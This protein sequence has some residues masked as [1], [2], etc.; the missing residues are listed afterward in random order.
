LAK[1]PE[2]AVAAKD[3][4]E[5]NW[6]ERLFVPHRDGDKV[7]VPVPK[8]INDFSENYLVISILKIIQ[9]RGWEACKSS[10]EV[11]TTV[12]K[13]E[14]NMFFAGYVAGCMHDTCGKRIKASNAYE[15]GVLSAQTDAVIASV[16]NRNAHIRK[17]EHTCGKIL[18]EMGGFVREHWATRSA[19]AMLF[20]DLP[21]P[22][23][24]P[25]DLPSYML[26][27]GELIGKIVR[28]SLPHSNG[29][30]FRKEELAYLNGKYAATQQMLDDI[31]RHCKAPGSDFANHFWEYID[32]LSS[33]A[34]QIEKDLGV[35]YAHRA[36]VL[37]RQGSKKKADIKWIRLSLEE[38]IDQLSLSE[39]GKLFDP[40]GL[41]GFTPVTGQ[42]R[43]EDEFEEWLTK[44]YRLNTSD[45]LYNLK[46]AVVSS[47]T[48]LRE[49]VLASD[50]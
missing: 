27:G 33:K 4:K 12:L 45:E 47:Y 43:N 34:K 28:K 1:F 39:L 50:E 16:G 41:P 25:E 8:N 42:A 6:Q 21:M 15:R 46:L 24:A 13:H 35:L 29:G 7:I 9:I 3:I 49:A 23:L 22:K 26:T 38:K 32:E 2:S 37:F 31:H 48:L 30:I 18:S 19:I 40:C 20:K 17:T 11:K 14:K 44:K 5:T 36:K 10:L